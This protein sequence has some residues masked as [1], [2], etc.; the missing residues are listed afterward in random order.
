M[1]YASKRRLAKVLATSSEGARKD[2]WEKLIQL[3]KYII[4][5]SPPPQAALNRA[6]QLLLP[7]SAH[8]AHNLL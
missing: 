1:F 7:C 5:R 2:E 3:K 4:N 8:V 6:R